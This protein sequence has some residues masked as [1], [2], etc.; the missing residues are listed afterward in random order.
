[1]EMMS[2]AA[3]W[4]ASK[5]EEEPR[6]A[7]DII[8]VYTRI[9]QK[10]D[11]LEMAPVEL[12]DA[13]KRKKDD[14]VKAER[15]MLKELGF[16]VHVKHPHK[17][18]VI[19]I[20]QFLG[21]GEEKEFIQT[22][23]M[24]T[25][26]LTN[27]EKIISSRNFMNDSFRSR[28]LFVKYAPI[29]IACTCVFLAARVLQ[30]PTSTKPYWFEIFDVEPAEVFQI[31]THIMNLYT[32]KKLSVD[33]LKEKVKTVQDSLR[34]ERDMKLA[35]LEKQKQSEKKRKKEHH[36]AHAKTIGSRGASNNNSR[37]ES[38]ASK[39]NKLSKPTNSAIVVSK[40]SNL[41]TSQDTTDLIMEELN[42]TKKTNQST[43]GVTDQKASG[44]LKKLDSNQKNNFI[45][46]SD[47]NS[48][49]NEKIPDGKG[50]YLKIDRS[51]DRSKSRSKSKG[52]ENRKRDS[53]DMDTSSDDE[54]AGRGSD[55]SM[56]GS[57]RRNGNGMT[58]NT[59]KNS[60]I[61]SSNN[62]PK[63]ING[64]HYNPDGTIGPNHR[65]ETREE[66]EQRRRLRRKE[67]KEKEDKN[68]KEKSSSSRSHKSS[69]HKHSSHKSSRK[70]REKKEEKRK[71]VEK[72]GEVVL[73]ADGPQ[74]KRRR[75]RS[76]SQ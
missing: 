29:K 53:S 10:R 33:E 63:T 34:K 12:N 2:M 15:F 41:T 50:G 6:R 32:L 26:I 24:A 48:D 52:K 38:P 28:H 11:Q 64:L 61:Q 74:Y 9:E 44:S 71:A 62:N 76:V 27:L 46:L 42:K 55:D 59:K 43:N 8:N 25:K 3:I 4:L 14:L 35:L 13:Y 5:I 58:S 19:I 67:K 70:D 45:E 16:C 51:R 56:G 21:K 18:I 20:A 7:R 69:K 65:K 75:S 47:E 22:S 49:H 31:C 37:E 23:W 72:K 1:M 54:G 40:P 39:F 66:R 36:A 73:T 30:I 60:H 17:M 68:K 57:G